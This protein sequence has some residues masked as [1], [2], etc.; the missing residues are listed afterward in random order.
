MKIKTMQGE[1][2]IREIL[3]DNIIDMAADEFESTADW[4]KLAKKSNK[5][6]VLEMINLAQYFREQNNN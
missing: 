4:V 5:E 2:S 3:I 6:L 1:Q